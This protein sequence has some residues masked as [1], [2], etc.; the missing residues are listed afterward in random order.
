MWTCTQG[1]MN[2][3]TKGHVLPPHIEMKGL[4][5]G[6]TALLLAKIRKKLNFYRGSI[7]LQSFGSRMTFFV[8]F[9]FCIFCSSVLNW[10]LVPLLFLVLSWSFPSQ[11]SGTLQ[12][13]AF[14]LQ[15]SRS[16]PK[17]SSSTLSVHSYASRKST[18]SHEF[19]F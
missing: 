18:N 11:H 10:K 15:L 8:F 5:F 6:P 4:R 17:P 19:K 12:K 2:R 1:R 3:G 16:T 14:P 7:K 13:L 9:L